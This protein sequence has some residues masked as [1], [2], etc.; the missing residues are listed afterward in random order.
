MT[1]HDTNESSMADL[2]G[3]TPEQFNLKMQDEYYQLMDEAKMLTEKLNA[4]YESLLAQDIAIKVLAK[5]NRELE[6]RLANG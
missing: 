2:S 4:A 6:E 5:A 1:A 3:V